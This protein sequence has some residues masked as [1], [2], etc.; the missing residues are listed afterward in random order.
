MVSLQQS[1]LMDRAAGVFL[2]SLLATLL[3]FG[4][5]TCSGLMPPDSVIFV[6]IPGVIIAPTL[7]AFALGWKKHALGIL[8]TAVGVIF[9]ILR[10]GLDVRSPN[11][12]DPIHDDCFGIENTPT[13]K[14]RNVSVVTGVFTLHTWLSARLCRVKNGEIEHVSDFYVGRSPNRLGA[15]HSQEMK[16]TLVLGDRLTD[17]GR[18]TQLG[19]SG[20]SRGS[21][22]IGEVLNNIQPVVSKSVSGRLFRGKTHVV[23]AESDQAFELDFSMG[24][25]EFAKRNKG[26][27]LFVEVVLN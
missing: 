18:I 16:I 19:S 23:Y 22:S 20:H 25:E 10:P 9:F 17:A 26:D 13:T 27:C 21:G 5:V 2:W 14:Y 11:S 8:V 12:S 3:L 7:F 4:I 1:A 15:P 6:I 24:A